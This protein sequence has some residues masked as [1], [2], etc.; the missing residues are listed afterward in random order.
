MMFKNRILSLLLL[1]IVTSCDKLDELTQFNLNYTTQYTIA[2]STVLDLPISIFTPEVT[3][4]SESEFEN[5]DTR[6]DLIESIV[7]TDLTLTIDTPQNGNFDFLNDV[8][9]FITA[10]DLP[11]IIIASI[12]DIPENGSFQVSL[13]TT[14]NE[15]KEYIKKDSYTLKV[16]TVTDGT[17][18]EDHTIDISTTFAVDAKILGL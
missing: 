7:L 8:E 10:E 12:N 16:T 14:G 6:S 4:N 1:I 15:L 9:I 3:T 11:E 5:N 17:I 13:N 2:S 18:T